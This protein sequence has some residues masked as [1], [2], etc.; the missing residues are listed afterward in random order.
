MTYLMI[1]VVVYDSLYSMAMQ[2]GVFICFHQPI[3]YETLNT[4]LAHRSDA[5]GLQRVRII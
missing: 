4:H 3:R 1:Y 2:A 5:L